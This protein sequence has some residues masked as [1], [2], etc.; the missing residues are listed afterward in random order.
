MLL[1]GIVMNLPD[2]PDQI[3]MGFFLQ[4]FDFRLRQDIVIAVLFCRR[5]CDD[6]TQ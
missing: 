1:C 2:L 4:L 6:G 5:P 3:F